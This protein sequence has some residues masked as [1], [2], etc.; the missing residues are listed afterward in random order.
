M[1]DR[2]DNIVNHECDIN[3]LCKED[4]FSHTKKFVK[5]SDMW[6]LSIVSLFWPLVESISSWSIYEIPYGVK[7]KKCYLMHNSKLTKSKFTWLSNNTLSNI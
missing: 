2:K 6:L 1:S 5:K 3:L 7:G 4:I